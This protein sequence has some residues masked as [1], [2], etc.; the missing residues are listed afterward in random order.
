LE[1][2]GAIPFI[3]AI[4]A[5][6]QFNAE[7]FPYMKSCFEDRSC[8]LLKSSNEADVAYKE[9]EITKEEYAQYIETDILI[10]ELSNIKQSF[11]DSGLVIY[12]RIVKSKKRDRAT[13]LMYGLSYIYRLEIEKRSNYYKKTDDKYSKLK[14]YIN[15]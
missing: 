7:F 6:T 4:K 2:D 1:L 3:I 15:F 9:N 12:E 14:S 10:Q 13:S 8:K 5:T 11:T